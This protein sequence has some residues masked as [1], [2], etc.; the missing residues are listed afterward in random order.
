MAASFPQVVRDSSHILSVIRKRSVCD[1]YD[2][3]CDAYFV[4]DIVCTC[5]SKKL[6]I[7]SS[8]NVVL[9][10]TEIFLDEPV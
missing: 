9:S 6:G 7:W 4:Y 5:G 2:C 3:F 8:S 10:K 1:E